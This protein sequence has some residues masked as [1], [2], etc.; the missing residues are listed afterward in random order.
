[1]L[2]D[3]M[4]YEKL[5]DD[6]LERIATEYQNVD[7]REGSMIFN[8]V[9]PQAMEVANLYWQLD[10]IR[11]EGFIG[12]ASRYGIL[13]KC[14]ELGIDIT[15]YDAKYGV[16]KGEFNIQVPIGSRWNCD[17]YNY[18]VVSFIEQSGS[19]YKYRLK[20]ETIGTAPNG[21]FG[22]LTPITDYPAGLT[23]SVL[24]EVIVEGE[25]ETSDEKIVE[26]FFNQINGTS[27]DGNK[28]QYQRWADEYNGIG[29]S[30]IFPLWN[31]DNTVKVSILSVSNSIASTELIKE[32]QDYLDPNSTG[33]GDG[34]A[35]IGAIVTVTT[36]TEKKI[37]ISAQ[38]VLRSGYTSTELIS[39][40]VS[41]FLSTLAYSKSVVNYMS[42]GA[43]VLACEA[44]ESVSNLLIDNDIEDIPL[45]DEEVPTL[46]NA[47]WTVA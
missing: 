28:A 39:S 31:G 26:A 47:T 33:M 2:Y 12:T 13:E 46:G 38:V 32:F 24:T 18:S 41:K 27:T 5:K 17:I 25:N 40:D 35:P 3:N 30:K 15:I 8:A 16:F 43:V 22:T 4:T 37:N 1:M 7:T 21:V 34:V 29:N 19:I 9:A 42:V 10:N 20:C 44:V 6:K 23:S 45:G 11:N 14:K 36:A